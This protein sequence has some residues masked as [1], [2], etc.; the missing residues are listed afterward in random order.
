MM[1]G[2]GEFKVSSFKFQVRANGFFIFSPEGGL[3]RRLG[4]LKI[5]ELG[6]GLEN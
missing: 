2:D 1:F 3:W 4:N 6:S 5:L